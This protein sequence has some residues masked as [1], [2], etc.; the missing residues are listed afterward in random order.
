MA[1]QLARP[2]PDR[3][4]VD[5]FEKK[6]PPKKSK[7]HART[8]VLDQVCLVS[9]NYAWVLQE[10]GNIHAKE[11]ENCHKEQRTIVQILNKL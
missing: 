11:A 4:S 5:D 2:K 1:W 10:T 8:D 3:K 7:E 6:G 9:R